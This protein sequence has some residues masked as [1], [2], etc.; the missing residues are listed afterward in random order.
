MKGIIIPTNNLEEASLV[1]GL[2][3]IGV[4]S[5]Q[6]LIDHFLDKKP[7]LKKR[8][9]R[10]KKISRTIADLDCSVNIKIEHVAEAI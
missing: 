7:I 6:Q 1:K 10:I 3:I 9:N 5:L 4:K 2:N 8:I